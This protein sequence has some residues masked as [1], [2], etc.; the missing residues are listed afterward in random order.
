M[1]TDSQIEIVVPF[2]SNF[3][4]VTEVSVFKLVLGIPIVSILMGTNV[5]SSRELYPLNSI[6]IWIG[7]FIWFL[8][9]ISMEASVGIAPVRPG[10]NSCSWGSD[11]S[12]MYIAAPIDSNSN[13]S[14]FIPIENPPS[15]VP[16]RGILTVSCGIEMSNC[17]SNWVNALSGHP[18]SSQ[19][20]NN[21]SSY[22]GHGIPSGPSLSPEVL[23]SLWPSMLNIL[24]IAASPL[25]RVVSSLT[26]SPWAEEGTKFLKSIR[27][28]IGNGKVLF[29]SMICN[30]FTRTFGL[31]ATLS[32]RT[33]L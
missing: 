19:P 25:L 12:S 17:K 5:N 13:L 9:I 4:L 33:F 32:A 3:I 31:F 8:K 7:N 29:K 16:S 1:F 24:F 30:L 22:D 6:S 23:W 26:L 2:L 28:F 21:Q 15:G 14:N 20:S 18:S 27:K 11:G 10:G